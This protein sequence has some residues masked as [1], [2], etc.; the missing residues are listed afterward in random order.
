MINEYLNDCSYMY[1]RMHAHTNYRWNAR[2]Y[3]YVHVHV[4]GCGYVLCKFH[5]NSVS[6]LHFWTCSLIL[7]VYQDTV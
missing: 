1:M 3:I 4:S 2:L 7:K 6:S 5:T